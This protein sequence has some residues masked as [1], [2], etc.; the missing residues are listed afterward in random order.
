V[1]AA[2]LDD[3]QRGRPPALLVIEDAH[4]ADEATLD[5]LRF[6]GRR[7]VRLPALLVITFRDDETG[8]THPLR[9]VTGELPSGVTRRVRLRPLSPVA[10]KTLAREAG[11]AESELHAIT[12]GNPFF[13]TE[14]LAAGD[15]EGEVPVTVRDAVLAARPAC[16]LTRAR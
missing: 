9:R 1:F 4:W 6:I 11:R 5:F 12:G 8:P 7:I 14:L 10:V 2:A 16:R 15:E 3:L 13:V